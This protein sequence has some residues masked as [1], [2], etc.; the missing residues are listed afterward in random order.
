MR[1]VMRKLC[2]TTCLALAFLGAG[3]IRTGQEDEGR[4]P[5]PE[6]GPPSLG[7]VAKILAELP[8]QEE[9]LQEV[10]DA[11]GASSGNGYD[12][13]YMMS[14][15]FSNPGAGV[16]SGG[17]ATRTGAYSSPLRDLFEDYFK[18]HCGTRA[19]GTDDVSAYID[20]LKFSDMQIYWPYS[21]DWDGGFPI[22][23]FDPGYGAESNVG[24][25]I[26]VAP[27]GSRS[28][29]EVIVD[30]AVAASRPVWVINNN[31]DSA[32]TPLDLI[33]AKA[34]ESTVHEGRSLMLK[35]FTMLRNYDSWFGG[36]SEFFVKC[37]SASGFKATTD[38]DLK[39][40]TPS[41]T[42]FMVVVRRGELKKDVTM[43]TILVSEF[44]D[45][46]DKV[47]FLVIEDDGG[48]TTSWK[49][50]ATVK[51]MSKSYG[52]DIEIPYKDKDDVVWR[53][54]LS[55]DFFRTGTPVTG[56]FGD[57]KITFALE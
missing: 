32:F 34:G 22:V 50:S 25:E 20:A 2:L 46:I 56:R 10:H 51:Y 49:C 29:T 8:L 44:T 39:L 37:G 55:G 16:G 27:D 43:D 15:L 57:V 41:V 31:D 40:Y 5:A 1:S 13:E 35:S 3:C 28:I 4:R 54:Q 21:E 6:Q 38:S 30:E 24:Y 45:E 33:T 11:V 36:A 47:A 14:D 42:D 26:S 23:T 7:E 52:F 53:G 48:E 18:E 9:H 19:G 12:E 17:R